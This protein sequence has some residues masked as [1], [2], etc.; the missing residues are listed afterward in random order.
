MSTYNIVASTDEATVVS[1]YA[2]E[3]YARSEKYQS[4][5]ELEKGFI[6]LLIT[7]GYEYLTIHNESMLTSNLR[8]Q[9][10]MINDYSF[11]D[12]EWNKFFTDK[13]ANTNEGIVQKTR[14]IQ[15]DYVQLLEKMMELRR[16]SIY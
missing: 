9:L 15:E 16:I 12:T 6:E 8:K 2:T 11:T 5:A 14:K 4:E 7:Q 3:Y 10:E 13:I 1:E